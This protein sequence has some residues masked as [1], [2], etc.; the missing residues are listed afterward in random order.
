MGRLRTLSPVRVALPGSSGARNDSTVA[1]DCQSR[2][3]AVS[4]AGRAPNDSTFAVLPNKSPP[5]KEGSTSTLDMPVIYIYLYIYVISC[6][7]YIHYIY[8]CI[9]IYISIL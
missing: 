3:E 7:I 6:I 9:Y 8:I 5:P 1:K 2:L 4:L